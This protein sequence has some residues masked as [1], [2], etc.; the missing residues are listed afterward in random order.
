MKLIE[1]AKFFARQT[2]YQ[3]TSPDEVMKGVKKL[4]SDPRRLNAFLFLLG[5]A[6]SS[7]AAASAHSAIAHAAFEANMGGASHRRMAQGNRQADWEQRSDASMLADYCGEL[8][9]LCA[10]LAA[11]DLTD[12]E[13]DADDARKFMAELEECARAL[14]V[15]P[16]GHPHHGKAFARVF[17]RGPGAQMR[18]R[19]FAAATGL[20][21]VVPVLHPTT[22]KH[23]RPDTFWHA[24]L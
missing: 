21:G 22:A 18:A 13:V 1:A 23:G 5:A 9:E 20:A 10:A 14:P 6:N 19:R 11:C 7:S 24:A 16:F 4:T 8:H 12:V 3:A 15:M 17:S 2:N